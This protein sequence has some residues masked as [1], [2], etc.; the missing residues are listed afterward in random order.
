MAENAKTETRRVPTRRL[1]V[2]PDGTVLRIEKK[3]MHAMDLKLIPYVYGTEQ[4]AQA[5]NYKGSRVSNALVTPYDPDAPWTELL[6]PSKESPLCQQCGQFEAEPAPASPFMQ[7]VGAAK[8]LITVI[9]DGIPTGDDK[10][11]SMGEG[12]LGSMASI[13]RQFEVMARHGDLDLNQI[14]WLSI[15]RCAGRGR[16]GVNLRIK[17]NWCRYHVIDDLIK[18][19]PKLIIAV[20]SPVLAHLSHK[21]NANDWSGRVLTYRGWPDNWLTE[22]RYMLPRPHPADPNA[23]R[24]IIGH[25]LFGP[26]PTTRIPLVPLMAPYMATKDRNYVVMQRFSEHLTYAVKIAKEGWTQPNYMKPW[27]RFTENVAEAEAGLKEILRHPGLKIAF[28][29]ET[30]GLRGWLDS[31]RIV[32][33]MF[34]WVDPDNGKPRSIGF[35]FDFPESAMLPY[36]DRLRPLVWKVLCESTLVGHNLT[37]DLLYT[38]ATFCAAIVGQ[39]D[40]RALN[41]KRDKLL[42]AL[43]HAGCLD[44]WHMAFVYRQQRERL[45]LEHMAYRFVP[46]MAGYDEDMSLLID[47]LPLD[48][49]PENQPQ[50]DAHY[51]RC[52]REKWN[53]HLVPYVMGDVETTYQTSVVLSDKLAKTDSYEIPLAMPNAP[54]RFRLFRPPRRDFVYDKIMSPASMVLTRMMARGMYVDQTVVGGFSKRERVAENLAN[55]IKKQKQDFLKLAQKTASLDETYICRELGLND[56]SEL[57]LDSKLHLHKL[58]FNPR[59]LNLPVCRLTKKG[60]ELYGETAQDWYAKISAAELDRNPRAQQEDVDRAVAAALAEY[61]AIDKFTLNQ[62]SA[63]HPVVQPLLEYR[64]LF[65]LQTAYLNPLLPD[66][67]QDKKGRLSHLAPDGCVHASFLLTGTRGGRLSC[68]DPNLQQLPRDG[69]VKELYTSRFKERGCMY[70]ADLSQIELRLMA[71]ACGDPTMVKAYEDDIDLHS[72]TASRIYNVPYEH[73]TK[74]HMKWLQDNKRDKEA[75]KLELDRVTAKTVNFLTGYGGGAFGLQNVLATKRINKDIDECQKIIELFFDSYPALRTLLQYYKRFILDNLCA[76]TVFG[77][78]RFFEDAASEDGEIQSKALRA[79]C[80]HL[81]QSTASD[82]MLIALFVIEETM[83]TYGLESLLVSTVHDSLVIDCI[84][85]ELEDVHNI[86]YWTLNNFPDV[87]KMVLGQR[88]DTSWML[89]PFAGDC[90][91]G[92]DYLHTRKIPKKDIDWDKLLDAT[93]E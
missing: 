38:F 70:Q 64:K 41:I 56:F 15:T 27:Y 60:R 81:I 93:D 7:P 47:L 83:R 11:G 19:P 61:A 87:L 13:K 59:C 48:L 49:N 45:G 72:L 37:F 53:S 25:P 88:Y 21:T 31:A 33:I 2:K 55:D 20:G 54:G 86:V 5:R 32:S 75:K 63:K 39:Y 51:L 12:R 77:R 9:L 43:V 44:T 66:D 78:V 84:R 79:G 24:K 80:N 74:E 52:P 68:R 8:P 17:G 90:E 50:H 4:V 62:L 16:G 57:D 1:F 46:D 69:V 22:P 40:D 10:A 23:E 73:F 42:C 18:H 91:I 29:T 14:R 36:L 85:D 92:N 58:F 3:S 26:P 34:R 28:D 6:R 30:T 67:Q 89:V 35:P 71:A 65:K 76:V 82:M